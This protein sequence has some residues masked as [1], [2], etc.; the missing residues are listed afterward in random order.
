[1]TLT[2]QEVHDQITRLDSFADGYKACL[3]WIVTKQLEEEKK[4][5]ANAATTDN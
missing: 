4:K 2:P 1:M 3:N 5:A